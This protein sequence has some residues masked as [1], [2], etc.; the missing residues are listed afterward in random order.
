MTINS[1][2]YYPS[3]AI[4][5]WNDS[6]IQELKKVAEQSPR[7]VARIC[8]HENPEDPL[9]EMI[10]ALF[11]GSPVRRHRHPQ[12]AE[13]YHIIEGSVKLTFYREDGSEWDSKILSTI[14][15]EADRCCRIQK[16]IWHFVEPLTEVV[17]FHE[18][19]LGPFRPESTDFWS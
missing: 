11:Q 8:L 4:Y 14:D 10:I 6:V 12:Q 1:P 9:H 15:S 5:S 3:Q 17:V 19:K 13:S 2:V 7:K 16:G 18:V